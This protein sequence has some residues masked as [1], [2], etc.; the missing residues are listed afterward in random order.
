MLA[1]VKLKCFHQAG[2]PAA[3]LGH[4]ICTQASICG[5]I[6][7]L[8]GVTSLSSTSVYE[9]PFASHEAFHLLEQRRVALSAECP[10]HEAPCAA[11][12]RTQDGGFAHVA[13]ALLVVLLL[14]EL[15]AVGIVS[16]H[17]DDAVEAC[18]SR[19]EYACKHI[20]VPL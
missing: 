6:A 12:L 14:D 18:S 11:L 7:S 17:A 16:E 15:A 13:H 20:E 10:Q 9:I 3:H 2:A 19:P 1:S 5:I 4:A 8:S